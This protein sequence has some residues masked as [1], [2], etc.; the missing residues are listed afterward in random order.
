MEFCWVCTVMLIILMVAA[1]AIFMKRHKLNKEMEE[2]RSH[3]SK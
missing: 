1:A 3:L 2:L